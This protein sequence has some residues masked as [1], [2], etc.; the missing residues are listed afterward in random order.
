M[1][2]AERQVDRPGSHAIQSPASVHRTRIA[3]SIVADRPVITDW[4]FGQTRF[5]VARNIYAG[6][7]GRRVRSN[8]RAWL[9]GWSGPVRSGLVRW[10]TRGQRVVWARISRIIDDAQTVQ[11]TT[12]REIR[13][14]LTWTYSPGQS[15]LSFYTWC[16]TFSFHHH[17]P[18]IYNIKR[19]TVI[20]GFGL[21]SGLHIV[22]RS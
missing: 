22:G 13:T 6:R 14:F 12:S 17:Y 8:R 21:G 10:F 16:R 9:P 20:V 3:A 19:S 7:S 2:I 4:N 1:T 5:T 18:P 15:P 11:P